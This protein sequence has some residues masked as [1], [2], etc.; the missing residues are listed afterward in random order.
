MKPAKKGRY[1]KLF[2]LA[3]ITL[4]CTHVA[5]E[6]TYNVRRDNF[7]EKLTMTAVLRGTPQSTFEF[8]IKDGAGL[9]GIFGPRFDCYPGCI[10]NIKFGDTTPQSFNATSPRPIAR[11]IYLSSPQLQHQLMNHSG[12]LTVRAPSFDA[13]GD[14]N[15]SLTEPLNVMRF[16][17]A[18]KQQK[19]QQACKDN[20][21]NED[22]SICMARP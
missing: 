12:S 14:L 18:D 21:V 2:L 10:V 5:A 9:V 1:M 20:A 4:T 6:W 19:K 8:I 16:S 3:A 11:S 22:Y 13:M 17:E 15:F 7:D